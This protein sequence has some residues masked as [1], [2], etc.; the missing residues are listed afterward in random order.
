MWISLIQRVGDVCSR[1]QMARGRVAFHRCRTAGGKQTNQV[2]HQPHADCLCW[3]N[4]CARAPPALLPASI[5]PMAEFASAPHSTGRSEV[6]N[7]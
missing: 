7:A 1:G 2:G 5:H 6:Y 3:L 4:P